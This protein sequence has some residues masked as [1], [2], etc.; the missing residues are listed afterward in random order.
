MDA[1]E[2]IEKYSIPVLDGKYREDG[3]W[4]HHLRKFPGALFDSKGYV[5]FITKK[6]YLNCPFLQHKQDLHVKPNISVIPGYKLFTDV[7]FE[8]QEDIEKSV[9]KSRIEI[10]RQNR[11]Q[12]LVNKIKELYSYKCQICEIQLKIRNS[13]YYIEVH[14]IWPL[15]LPHD[16][17]DVQSN[18]ICAC[19]NCHVL[20]DQKVMKINP[21]TL[22]TQKH[23]I[24]SK[25][26]DYHNKM[27]I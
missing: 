26:I 24:D 15:G 19:P 7:E 1:K 6:E 27:V 18:M 25:Y 22:K 3:M 4:F 5:I 11:N 2:L 23:Q 13:I 17:P 21:N 9:Q 20:L 16:G 12:A 14:H 10:F 8:I